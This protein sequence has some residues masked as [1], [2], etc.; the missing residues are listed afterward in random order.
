MIFTGSSPATFESRRSSRASCCAP[1]TDANGFAGDP[2]LWSLPYGETQSSS[3]GAGKVKRQ[4][5]N[6][7]LR[8]RDLAEN[9][10]TRCCAEYL[11]M[12]IAL[13]IPIGLRQFSQIICAI[14]HY[15]FR[16]VVL[17]SN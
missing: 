10:F 17:V 8:A 6:R 4:D 11:P 3:A 7:M 9:V 12:A 1:A 16:H 15:T 14:L 13:Q 2:G 5:Q